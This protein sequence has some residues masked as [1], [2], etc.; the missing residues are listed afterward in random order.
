MDLFLY[1]D[2]LSAG[3]ALALPACPGRAVYVV[4]GSLR[5]GDEE[6]AAD[7]GF[8]SADDC[9]LAAGPEGSSLWRWELTRTAVAGSAQ[10]TT[11]QLSGEVPESL[12]Q[13]GAFL[14][15][16]SVSFPPGG[17]ALLHTHP[18]PGI[19]RLIEGSIRI[20]TQGS[21]TAFGPGGCWFEAGPDPV[22]AQADALQPSR[23]IRAMV[24]PDAF[25]NRSSISYENE[26]DRDKPKQQ[27]Y[28]RFG[29]LGIVL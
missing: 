12:S 9:R 18:G 21:S 27:S 11:E 23:F 20:D 15:L 7:Q 25:R 16:D 22:F 8:V 4:A 6:V 17:A 19:R 5:R 14:R 2:T 13:G 29:E 24:L 10:R 26:S 28:R 1:E 3:D